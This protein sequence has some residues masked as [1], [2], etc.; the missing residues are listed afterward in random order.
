M[1]IIIA[2][3]KVQKAPEIETIKTCFKNN[4]DGAGF[5]YTYNNKV[6]IDKGYMD[7]NSFITRYK[8]LKKKFNNFK[9]KSLLM[10]FRISTS[11]KTTPEYTHPYVITDKLKDMKII[12]AYCNIGVMHNGVLH[13]YTPKDNTSNDTMQYIKKYLYKQYKSKQLFTDKTKK[14]IEKTGS[15]FAILTKK[16]NIHLYGKFIKDGN[17]YSNDSYIEYRYTYSNY[18]S[19]I[20]IDDNTQVI[21]DGYTIESRYLKTQVNSYFIYNWYDMILYECIGND[22]INEI[23]NIDLY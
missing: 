17:Y 4:P 11:G 15:R 9:N 1:C 22:I 19:N 20:L 5:M 12:K 6:V 10:H 23:D 14:A 21:I 13:D 7:V 3:T 16:D 2:K 18:D 8:F